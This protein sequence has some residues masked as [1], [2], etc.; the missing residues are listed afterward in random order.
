M[1]I[2][3]TEI[4]PKK[5]LAPNI[6]DDREA[7]LPHSTFPFHLNFLNQPATWSVG[8]KMLSTARS[9]ASM[10]LRGAY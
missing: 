4:E 6:N 8:C 3:L 7:P 9:T 5:V 2:K 10:A 1:E